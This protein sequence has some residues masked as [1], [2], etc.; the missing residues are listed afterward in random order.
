MHQQFSVINRQGT[1]VLLA[2][3]EI[4]SGPATEIIGALDNH[5]YNWKSQ[6]HNAVPSDNTYATWTINSPYESEIN[7]IGFLIDNLT[8]HFYL[9]AISIYLLLMLS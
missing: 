8:D 6:F 4:D 7:I 9:A 2:V 1:T 5:N 3:P